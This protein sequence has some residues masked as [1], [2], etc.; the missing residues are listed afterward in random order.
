MSEYS[1]YLKEMLPVYGFIIP[2]SL[3]WFGIY[4]YLKRKLKRGDELSAREKEW[5]VLSKFAGFCF[6]IFP[7]IL[8]LIYPLIEKV[9]GILISIFIGLFIIIPSLF[10]KGKF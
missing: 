3:I 4:F 2:I 5:M 9:Y 8:I 6:I 10:K 7:L 1:E